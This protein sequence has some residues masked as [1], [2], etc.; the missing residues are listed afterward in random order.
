MTRNDF[1]HPYDLNIAQKDPWRLFK[2]MSEFINGFDTLANTGPSISLF[3]SARLTKKTPTTSF[4]MILPMLL[5][6]RDFLS[7]LEQD[8][9]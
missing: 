7:L 4:R 2:I 1:S 8:P 6:R 5:H 9:D 3:G